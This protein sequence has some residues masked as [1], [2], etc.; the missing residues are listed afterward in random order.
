MHERRHQVRKH[1][2]LQ[3]SSFCTVY[4]G[5]CSGLLFGVSFNL[6]PYIYCATSLHCIDTLIY[7]LGVCQDVLFVCLLA[8]LNSDCCL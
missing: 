7:L 1:M 8:G 4:I 6:S 5:S 2:C 3:N